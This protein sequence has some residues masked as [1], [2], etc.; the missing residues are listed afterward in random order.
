M[1]RDALEPALEPPGRDPEPVHQLRVAARRATAAVDQFA[2][3]MG[4]R[5]GR[6]LRAIV[7]RIRRAAGEA[8]D[9]DVFSI[10]LRER[11]ESA[12]G[13]Q[14]P[15]FDFLIGYAAGAFAAI[16]NRRYSFAIFLFPSLLMFAQANGAG[17]LALQVTILAAIAALIA[18]VFK[19]D[20]TAAPTRP[21][22]CGNR[23]TEKWDRLHDEPLPD[24]N[25]P[26]DIRP[27]CIF[28]VGLHSGSA[29]NNPPR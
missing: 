4:K 20:P 10:A 19:P 25:K 3:T 6:R 11:R 27:H 29:P 1:L 21:A 26:T 2:S 15:G 16:G 23:P 24:A 17:M 12:S 8:R 18:I 5:R 22:S 9:W 13:E 7:K 14:L 28:S